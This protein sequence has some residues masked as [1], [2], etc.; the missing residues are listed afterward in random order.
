MA[1]CNFGEQQTDFLSRTITTQGITP[2]KIK[3]TKFPEKVG[4]PRSRKV[5]QTYIGLLKLYR[6]YLRVLVERFTPI[7]VSLK[8]TDAKDKIIVTPELTN[9]FQSL[10]ET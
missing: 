7:F 10:N 9:E 8:T 4:F 5:S 3:V 2:Q 1:K 6:V